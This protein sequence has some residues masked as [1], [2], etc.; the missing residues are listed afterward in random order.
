M[1]SSQTV[2]VLKPEIL[3][4]SNTAGE[5]DEKI[6]LYFEAGA[7]EVWICEQD[8]HRVARAPDA[9]GRKRHVTGLGVIY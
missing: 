6:A 1:L 2:Y 4:P 5:I 7:R 3:S 8:A 9:N